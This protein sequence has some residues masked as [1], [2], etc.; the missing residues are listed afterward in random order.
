MK[1]LVTGGSSM[2]GKHLQKILPEAEY[3]SSQDCNLLNLEQTQET[4]KNPTYS[5]NSSSS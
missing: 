2:V 1:M 4:F 3:L 5:R